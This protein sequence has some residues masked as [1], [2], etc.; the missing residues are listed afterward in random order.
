LWLAF[1]DDLADAKGDDPI[2]RESTRLWC[3]AVNGAQTTLDPRQMKE[4]TPN[5]SYGGHAFGFKG[6]P[7]TKTSQFAEFLA[8]RE[9]ILPWIAEYSPYSL[10]TRDDPPVFLNYSAPPAIGQAQKD[11]TH[12]ANFGVKLQEHCKAIGV[13]CQLA[14]PD[15]PDVK[16]KS[17]EAYLIDSL[18]ASP[19]NASLDK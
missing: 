19:A 14:Y 1:H 15:A 16:Y 13:D 9:G 7:M 11:P 4:W 3:A 17:V 2:A 12:S 6:D 5:S 18:T 10:V 8:G